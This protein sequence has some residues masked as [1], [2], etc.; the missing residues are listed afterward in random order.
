MINLY[1]TDVTCLDDNKLFSKYYYLCSNT[2]KEKIDKLKFQKDKNLSLGAYT[3]L[4]IALKDQKLNIEDLSIQTDDNGKLFIENSNLNINLSHSGT[5]AICAISNKVIGCDIERVEDKNN[6]LIKI[7]QRYF[8]EDEKRI[9]TE[10]NS[11][12]FFFSLW[13]LKESFIKAIGLGLKLPLNDFS[14]DFST[15]PISYI[16]TFDNN[17]YFGYEINL[18]KDY[19]CAIC[20]LLNESPIVKE[21]NIDSLSIVEVIQ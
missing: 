18:D 20:S 15:K 5:K 4:N 19:K 1:V 9:I 6:D 7:A 8:S 13:T 16:Q 14:V 17:K 2:R 12:D 3:L 10:Q 21:I 11:N